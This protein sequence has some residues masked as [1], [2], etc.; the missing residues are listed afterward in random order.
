MI[1][2]FATYKALAGFDAETFEGYPY[3]AFR[4]WM[5][6]GEK[7][8]PKQQKATANRMPQKNS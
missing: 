6:S 3:L 8:I 1:A 2:G 4:L 5:E 7:L